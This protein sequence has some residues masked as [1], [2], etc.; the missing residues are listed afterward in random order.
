MPL[1]AR[2]LAP[3]EP[4]AVAR[5]PSPPTNPSFRPQAT[6]ISDRVPPWSASSGVLGYGGWRR[7]G[8]KGVYLEI[9]GLG[10]GLAG[11]MHLP[12]A[13]GEDGDISRRETMEIAVR[14]VYAPSGPVHIQLVLGGTA[15]DGISNTTRHSPKLCCQV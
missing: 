10:L 5:R 15:K 6:Q 14:V 12:L 2:F 4:E 8:I 13:Q 7:H 3:A 11:L 1:G 9:L